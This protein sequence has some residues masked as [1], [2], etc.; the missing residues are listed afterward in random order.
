MVAK[1]G[2][3]CLKIYRLSPMAARSK[4]WFCG[5]SIAGFVGSNPGGGMDVCL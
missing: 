3:L 2:Q 1:V 4:A 5:R